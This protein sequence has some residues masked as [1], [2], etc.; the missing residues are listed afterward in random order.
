MRVAERIVVSRRVC[1]RLQDNDITG[2][3]PEQLASLTK[4]VSFSIGGTSLTGLLPPGLFDAMPS[5]STLSMFDNVRACGASTVLSPTWSHNLYRMVGWLVAAVSPVQNFEGPLPALHNTALVDLDLGNSGLTGTLP[6]AWSA[7]SGTLTTL[8]V[9]QNALEVRSLLVE[10][11][12]ALGWLA[13]DLLT[14]ARWA[15]DH[16]RVVGTTDEAGRARPQFKPA[17]RRHT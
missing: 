2:S 17:E 8:Y 14:C 1:R 12:V 16:P 15:G 7:L 9:Q 6:D 5:L 13:G 4:L 11:A 10:A 3:I